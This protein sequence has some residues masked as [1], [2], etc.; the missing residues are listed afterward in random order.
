MNE[1]TI[2]FDMNLDFGDILNFA[3]QLNAVDGAKSLHSEKQASV[4]EVI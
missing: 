3:A 4:K 1:G 2:N